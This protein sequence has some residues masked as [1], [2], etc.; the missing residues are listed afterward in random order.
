MKKLIFK[1]ANPSYSKLSSE[2]KKQIL[3]GNNSSSDAIT[4]DTDEDC[5]YGMFCHPGTKTCKRL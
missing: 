1:E 2:E 3:G 4:C 5:P